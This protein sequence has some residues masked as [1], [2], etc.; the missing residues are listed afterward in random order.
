[1]KLFKRKK[2]IDLHKKKENE[3][4][5]KIKKIKIFLKR[6]IQEEKEKSEKRKKNQNV[7]VKPKGFIQRKLGV[8]VF[9]IAFG[10][11]FLVVLVTLIG[12]DSSSAEIDL[13]EYLEEHYNY[14]TSDEAIQFA[15]NFTKDYFTWKT[16]DKGKQN[17]KDRMELY[18]ADG[19][20]DYAGVDLNRIDW[21]S[22]FKNSELKK[23]EKQGDDLAH[24][25]FKV[26][27]ELSKEDPDDEKEKIV[28]RNTLY[29]VVPVAYDGNSFGVYELPKFTYIDEQ[30][31]LASVEHPKL[32]HAPTS[33]KSE[34][35]EFLETF[36]TSF[37][38]DPQEKLNYLLAVEN[39]TSGLGGTMEFAE[40]NAVDVFLPEGETEDNY[41]Y[42]IFTD[43][44]FIEPDTEL[45]IRTNYQLRIIV[46]EDRFMVSGI[47]DLEGHNIK[48]VFDESDSILDEEIDIDFDIDTY[49]EN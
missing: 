4:I 11:M 39:I 31:T 37:A 10:F 18:L 27:F 44:T 35:E 32:R 36:F 26:D 38:V 19:L 48:S 28:D 15:E 23:V 45:P 47:D 41:E 46:K 34:V 7:S 33:V 43:V 40:I 42:I 14:A 25:T 12:G 17:R 21:D 5:E 2:K 3:T 49:E 22:T 6:R 9:W 29:F 13:E 24:I 8:V 1:M 20:D 16:T 30:T